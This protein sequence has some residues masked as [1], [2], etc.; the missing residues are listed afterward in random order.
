MTNRSR[1]KKTLDNS[2][3]DQIIHVI[4][5]QNLQPGDRL[6]N[7]FD[8]AKQLGVGRGTVREAVRQLTCRNILNV[9]QGSGTYVATRTGVP[10]DPLGF[11]FVTDKAK[12]SFDLIE[13]RMILEPNIAALAARRASDDDCRQLREIMAEANEMREKDLDYRDADMRLHCMI[14]A[15]SHNSV[16]E[17]LIPIIKKSVSRTKIVTAKELEVLT[18]EERVRIINARHEYIVDAICRRDAEGARY[19][20]TSHLMLSYEFYAQMLRETREQNACAEHN[21]PEEG[22]K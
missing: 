9:V 6:P 7:E 13:I 16:S 20:M 11:A 3:A 15:C 14:A 10:D 12:L 21:G 17:T 19:A 18:H 1:E 5:D 2:V 22:G 8:L 4:L